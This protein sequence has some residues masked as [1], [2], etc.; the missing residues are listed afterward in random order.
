MTSGRMGEPAIV[1]YNTSILGRYWVVGSLFV[2]RNREI[3]GN[4]GQTTFSGPAVHWIHG[5][6]VDSHPRDYPWSSYRANAGLATSRL[7]TPHSEYLALGKYE[8][9]RAAAYR[10]LFRAALDRQQ[11][12]QSANRRDARMPREK[13]KLSPEIQAG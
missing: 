10:E 6:R 9:E 5:S 7:L 11:A 8:Q 13:P 2:G 1:Y 12:L 4:R 3:A